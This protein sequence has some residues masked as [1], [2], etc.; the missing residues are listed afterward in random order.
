MRAARRHRQGQGTQR[1]PTSPRTI[2]GLPAKP[3]PSR[4]PHTSL[5][6][7]GEEPPQRPNGSSVNFQSV[8]P[9]QYVNAT[10]IRNYSSMNRT[11]KTLQNAQREY[12]FC[13]KLQNE[14]LVKSEPEPTAPDG[15]TGLSREPGPASCR[16]SLCM[17][18]RRLNSSHNN[19]AS[20]KPYYSNQKGKRILTRAL[21]KKFLKHQ[22]LRI[23]CQFIVYRTT[24]IVNTC[25][26][27]TPP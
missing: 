14:L 22:S 25:W 6:S 18:W 7:S 10:N 2:K 8:S 26:M 27:L 11:V 19:T 15:S 4:K 1:W 24:L 23:S 16:R 17:T 3:P 21:D 5:G 13:P 20:K 12:E 9:S